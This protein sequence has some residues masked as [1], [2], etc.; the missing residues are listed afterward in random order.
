MNSRGK[1]LKDI[2]TRFKLSLGVLRTKQF[3]FLSVLI[4]KREDKKLQEIKQEIKKYE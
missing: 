4:K 2:Y 3:N 1:D